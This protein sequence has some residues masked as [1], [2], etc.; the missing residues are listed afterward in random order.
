MSNRGKN[1]KA[2]SIIFYRTLI[3][4]SNR[5]T[6]YFVPLFIIFLNWSD[7]YYG[8]IFAVSGYLA[9]GLIIGLGYI[10]DVKKRK[11][12]MI[13][14]LGAA[15][16]SMFLF[17]ATSFTDLKAWMI[18]AYSLFGVSRS[19]TQI[20]L[21][22]LLADITSTKEEKTRFFS[23]MHFFWN[24]AGVIAPLLGGVYLTIYAN[25]R[26]HYANFVYLNGSNIGYFNLIADKS[27][28]MNIILFIAIFLIV[29][30]FLTF[31]FPVPDTSKEEAGNL[32]K[33]E[34]WKNYENESKKPIGF[35]LVAFFFCE[36]IIGFTSGVAIPFIRKYMIED[37]GASDMEWA[38]ILALSNAGIAFGS[39]AIVPL[40]KKIGNEKILAI[41]HFAVPALALGL[42]LSPGLILGSTFF[43]L[44][45]SSANMSRPAWNSF[46]YSWLP[47]KYRGSSTGFVSAG[48]RLTR[49]LGTTIGGVIY[50]AAGKILPWT[51]P[52][53]TLAYPIAIMIPIIMQKFL[54]KKRNGKTVE[55]PLPES[56]NY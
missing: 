14:G 45:S 37:L 27:P 4:L 24:L 6:Q 11:Y 8:L 16:L 13:A 40:S 15:G 43:V 50:D 29:T 34:D 51:F 46:F 2:Y 33:G 12:T 22:T 41:L 49:A 35:Q 53:V 19:L 52:V 39:L 48:R 5:L 1:N 42:A 7:F 38:I 17:Y 18:T 54:H 21:T 30:M 26:T 47:P 25:F 32:S 20:S 3:G 28:Y 44:R 36:S 10:T 55:T 9:S 31:R 56:M 23:F